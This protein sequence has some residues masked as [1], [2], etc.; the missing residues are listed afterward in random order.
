MLTDEGYKRKRL[1]HQKELPSTELGEAANRAELGGQLGVR[2]GHDAFEM[3]V[4]HPD[5]D[6]S[7]QLIKPWSSERGLG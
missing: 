5:G 6:P 1:G 3:S 2:F 4:D 7:S